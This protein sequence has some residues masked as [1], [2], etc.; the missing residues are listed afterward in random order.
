MVKNLNIKILLQFISKLS[1]S[2]TVF[3]I[4]RK[5]S[6]SRPDFINSCYISIF[7]LFV[8]EENL[9]INKT[10]SLYCFI[11]FCCRLY[12]HRYFCLF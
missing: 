9:S 8:F 5:I 7:N 4:R 1:S 12:Y 10:R 2:Q 6:T 11:Y 3:S